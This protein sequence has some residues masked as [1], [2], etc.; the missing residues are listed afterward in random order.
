LVT[1]NDL[2]EALAVIEGIRGDGGR[3][4]LRVECS[5]IGAAIEGS[6]AYGS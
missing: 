5:E 6:L 4:I 1:Q 2:I 3:G